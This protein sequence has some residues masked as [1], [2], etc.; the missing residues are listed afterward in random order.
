MLL[1]ILRAEASGLTSTEKAIEDDFSPLAAGIRPPIRN[2]Y[3]GLA[4]HPKSARNGKELH[5]RAL[6]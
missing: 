6:P 1:N 4:Y 5:L 3:S 2:N